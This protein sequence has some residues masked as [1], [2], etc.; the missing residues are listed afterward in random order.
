[1][2]DPVKIIGVDVARSVPSPARGRAGE[3]HRRQLSRKLPADA[4]AYIVADSLVGGRFIQVTPVYQGGQKLAD[5][6]QIPMERTA[7]PVEWIRSRPNS[8]N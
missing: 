2:G 4:S 5:G 6:A 1:M 8:T 7:I 3:V